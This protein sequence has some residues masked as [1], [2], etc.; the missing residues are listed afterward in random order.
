MSSSQR[1]SENSVLFSLREL[2]RIEDDRIKKE[3]EATRAKVEAERQ[4]KEAAERAAR[5]AEERRIRDDAERVRM[6]RE[7][8]EQRQ[9]DDHMRLQE[10]ERRARVEGEMRINE[11]R[12]R[13]EIQHKK[14]HSP[15]KAV[16]SVA[17]VIVLIAGG[18]GYKMYSDHQKELQAARDERVRIEIEA[19]KKQA[20][21]E[22]RYASIEK[23]FAAKLKKATS[24]AEIEAL[25]KERLQQRLEAQAGRPS[26]PHASPAKTEPDKPQLN[27]PKG[28]REI[29]DNPLDGLGQL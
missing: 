10:A 13:L 15:V 7:A 12:M 2:R 22:A 23:D 29:S 24:Q 20:E 11:E 19:K 8:D 18:V 17:G 27:K 25:Q 3:Q 9:R 1:P 21:I 4:A 26:R 14:K 6:A 16:L 28:K 5:E